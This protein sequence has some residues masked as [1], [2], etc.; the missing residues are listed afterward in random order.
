MCVYSELIWFSFAAKLLSINDDP[1]YKRD[2]SN[3]YLRV[4]GRLSVCLCVCVYSELIWIF[5]IA[6]LLS[7]NNDP[8]YKRDVSNSGVVS[9][10]AKPLKG[11]FVV[12][13][14]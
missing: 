6:K 10:V 13:L 4:K 9:F 3:S 11:R 5:F 2:V 7:I 12:F 1:D 14:K 8:D